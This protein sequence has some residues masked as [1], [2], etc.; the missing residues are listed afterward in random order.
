MKYVKSKGKI[1]KH[2]ED[3]FISSYKETNIFEE[4][5]KVPFKW[6]GSKLTPELFAQINAFFLWTY[7]KWQA[8]SQIRLFYNTKD[9][10]WAAYPFPQEIRKGSMTTEDEHSEECRS[11][12]PDPWEYLGTAHH[13]CGTGAF[14]SSTDHKDEINQDG[15][16]YTIGKLNQKELDFHGRFSWSGSLFDVSLFD[17]VY[18]PKWILEAPDYLQHDFATKLLLTKPTVDDFTEF[19]PDEWQDSIIEKKHTTVNHSPYWQQDWQRDWMQEALPEEVQK[20]N[21]KAIIGH[22]EE[23]WTPIEMYK[24]FFDKE[25]EHEKEEITLEIKQLADTQAQ[26]TNIINKIRNNAKSKVNSACKAFSDLLKKHNKTRKEVIDY[27]A[28]QLIKPKSEETIDIIVA[29][30]DAGFDL[31]DINYMVKEEA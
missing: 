11:K 22:I 21:S 7:S 24:A 5:E 6:K 30:M 19:F 2:F 28:G 23:Y 16:H 18:V 12:F 10:I 17:M 31:E 25:R 8:E 27:L 13:H 9:K 29:I 3:E 14:Q 1:Y 26:A 15:F 4:K 20:G